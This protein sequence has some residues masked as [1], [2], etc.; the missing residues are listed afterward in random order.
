MKNTAESSNLDF[1]RAIAVTLV[2]VSHLGHTF[3]WDI[4]FIYAL[5]QWGVLIFFIHT[6]TVLMMSLDRM[7]LKGWRLFAGFYTRRIFRIY[8][9]SIACVIIV[10]ALRFPMTAWQPPFHWP[11]R[12]GLA[13]NLGL[14]MNLTGSPLVIGPLWSLPYEVQ[15]YL[16]LPILFLF[17]K[18]FDSVKAA[19]FV[20]LAGTILADLATQTGTNPAF[21]LPGVPCFLAGVVAYRMC[22]SVE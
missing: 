6:S 8:P 13:A 9:L 18:A 19:I 1:L 5:G 7:K 21:F 10:L 22:K 4:G 12:L 15:M 3:H 2:A 20:W 14:F 16:V 11:G 17:L